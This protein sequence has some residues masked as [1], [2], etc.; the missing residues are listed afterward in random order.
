MKRV[1]AFVIF[2]MAL[3]HADITPPW[4]L[5]ART[6]RTAMWIGDR[7]EYIVRVEYGPGLDFV[8]DHLKKEEMNL[9][10]FEIV[11]M[12]TTAGEL[13]KGRKLL[14]IRFLLTLY[15]TG[16]TDLAI[17]SFNLF[18]FIQTNNHAKEDSPAL[19]VTVPPLPVALRSAIVDSSA[20]IRDYK[21]VLPVRPAAWLLPMIAGWCGLAAIA[22]YAVWLAV[23]QIRS[24]FWKQRIAERVRKKSL[25]ESV[26]EIRRTPDESIEDLEDFYRRAAGILRAIAVEKLGDGAGLTPRETQAALR[27]AGTEERRAAAI[28]DLMEQC[29]LIRYSPGGLEQGRRLRPEFL[30]KLAELTEHH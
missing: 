1:L 11:D 9:Q 22:G 12:V 2:C 28:G 18:Y 6:N 15:E 23:I 29:D 30:Q 24:G 25:Q 8:R 17:P 27:A 20:G 14:E 7:L 5:T 3:V 26:E 4:S 19:T 21:D 10:P 16:R 13:P